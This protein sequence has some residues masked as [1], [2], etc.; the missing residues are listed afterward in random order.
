VI[1]NCFNYVGNKNRLLEQILPLFPEKINTFID[2]FAGSASVSL[3]TSASKY[4]I[5]D[6]SYHM[7][8]MLYI[9][10]RYPTE[11]IL[12]AVKQVIDDYGLHKTSKEE[13][14][15]LRD[16]YNK[17]PILPS[18]NINCIDTFNRYV[19]LY[20]LI[21]HSYNNFLVFTKEHKFSVPSGC[22]RCYFNSVL[23]KKLISV[24]DKL[25]DMKILFSKEDFNP[26]ISK[27]KSNSSFVY[28]DPPYLLSDDTYSRTLALK[29]GHSNE[30]NLYKSLND[31]NSRGVKFALSNIIE[32]GGD[33]NKYLEVFASKYKVHLIKS[34][35]NNCNHQKSKVESKE[36]LVTNY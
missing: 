35:Y 23:E 7:V 33:T 4:V 20:C 14:I 12:D 22:G 9:L 8:G 13:F 24:S 31:L 28:C 10:K 1:Y 11:V 25:K 32:K 29:W 19:K 18:D 34:T 2:V 15:K 30:E 3:N 21:T 16:D 5:N 6:K 27:V 17:Q 36:V 26:L